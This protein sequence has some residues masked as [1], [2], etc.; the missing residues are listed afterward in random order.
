VPTAHRENHGVIRVYPAGVIK[1]YP[2]GVIGVYPATAVSWL[3]AAWID[4]VRMT[5]KLDEQCQ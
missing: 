2:A 5:E 4:H 3:Y 1:V